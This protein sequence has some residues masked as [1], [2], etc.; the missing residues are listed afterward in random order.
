M[1]LQKELGSYGR[2]IIHERL[3]FRFNSTGPV[4]DRVR[5]GKTGLV[6][7]VTRDSAGLYT[8]NMRKDR[9]YVTSGKYITV[10]PS[11][12]QV[13]APTKY[14]DVHYVEGSWS[15]SGTY[16]TFK[17]KVFQRATEAVAAAAADP[18]NG[19]RISI[20]LTGSVNTVGQDLL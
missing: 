1:Q 18:D 20:T 7:S 9:P 13:A 16:V 5:D 8:I 3:S 10:H 15:S 11:L 6:V 4:L 17:V 14:C 12:S 2:Y 19:D